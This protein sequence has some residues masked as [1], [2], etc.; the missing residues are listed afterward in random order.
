MLVVWIFV[1]LALFGSSGQELETSL[2]S[3]WFFVYLF[4]I[5]ESAREKI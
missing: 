1:V 4:E 2:S 5:L 3:G